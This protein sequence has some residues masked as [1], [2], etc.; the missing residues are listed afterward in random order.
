MT[1]IMTLSS[2][3][4]LA[5][6]HVMQVSLPMTCAQTIIIDSHI[7]GLTLPGM[8]ELPGLSFRQSNFGNAATRAAPEPANVIGNFKQTDRDRFQQTACFD[9]PILSSLRFEMVGCFAKFDAGSM[10]QMRHHF[11]REIDVA[12]QAGADSRSAERQFLQDADGALGAILRI[13][14]LLRVTAEFLTEPHRR[15]IH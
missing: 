5:A 11:L 13:A 9:E 1:G 3:F 7:T 14:H 8:I 2:K 15:R 4:P 12:I 6:D 10:L